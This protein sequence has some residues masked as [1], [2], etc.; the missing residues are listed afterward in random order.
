MEYNTLNSGTVFGHLWPAPVFCKWNFTGLQAHFVVYI[1]SKALSLLLLRSPVVT[2]DPQNL[3]Y[4]LRGHGPLLEK[5]ADPS[6]RGQ[7]FEDLYR[8]DFLNW[9]NKWQ[10]NQMIIMLNR[11][12]NSR[13]FHLVIS[14]LFLSDPICVTGCWSSYFCICSIWFMAPCSY[15]PSNS[16]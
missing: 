10:Q 14:S 15:A 12:N 11:N 3:Q 16:A 1:L 9:N 6:P 2:T 8:N 5:S 13:L 4:F 7:R